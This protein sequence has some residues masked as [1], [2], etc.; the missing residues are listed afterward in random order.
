M[1]SA[2]GL[3]FPLPGRT[4]RHIYGPLFFFCLHVSQ[5][6]SQTVPL[7]KSELKFSTLKT[8][9]QEKRIFSNMGFLVETGFSWFYSWQIGPLS[10]F[11]NVHTVP[12]VMG[13]PARKEQLLMETLYHPAELQPTVSSERWTGVGRRQVWGLAC[14]GKS[15]PTAFWWFARRKEGGDHLPFLPPVQLSQRVV[16]FFPESSAPPQGCRFSST[17]PS[18]MDLHRL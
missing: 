7:S 5:P 15:T 11:C 10:T 9:K 17:E 18:K 6:P 16:P 1:G 14:C 13:E 3:T 12:Q 2:W 8:W 4:L